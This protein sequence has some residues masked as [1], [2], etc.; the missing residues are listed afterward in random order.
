MKKHIYTILLIA[1]FVLSV[2]AGCMLTPENIIPSEPEPASVAETTGHTVYT[3]SPSSESPLTEE[4]AVILTASDAKSVALTHA[5]VAAENMRDYEIEL[6]RERGEI[7]YEISFEYAGWE[8]E[9]EVEA[10]TGKIL[11]S[12]IE[13]DS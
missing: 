6:E 8:Y 2:F 1:I 9:Y 3:E 7:F 4:S 11:R 5:G 13:R 12:R 10:Y